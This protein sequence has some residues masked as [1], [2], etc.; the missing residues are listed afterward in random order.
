MKFILAGGVAAAA[1][2]GVAYADD[3]SGYLGLSRTHFDAD[4]LGFHG[5]ETSVSG[6]GAFDLRGHFQTQVDAEYS[7]FDK[8]DATYNGTINVVRRWNG[9]MAGAFVGGSRTDDETATL[10]GLEGAAYFHRF[11]LAG[12]VAYADSDDFD[13]DGAVYQMQGRFFV[14]RNFRIDGTASFSKFNTPLGNFDAT[15]LSLDGEY[16]FSNSALSIF[17]GYTNLD[18]DI[19]NV[20][21]DVFRLGFRVNTNEDLAYRDEHG[22]SL[23]RVGDFSDLF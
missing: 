2:L 10:A 5:D 20:N 15:E 7:D 1:L 21:A 17:G 16:K 3:Y 6:V 9:W 13:G 23:V 8:G 19:D 14:D 22:A 18:T 11:T 12:V 4:D